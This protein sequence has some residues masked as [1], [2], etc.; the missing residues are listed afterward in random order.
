MTI[1]AAQARQIH[2]PVC[3]QHRGWTR[4]DLLDLYRQTV[5]HEAVTECHWGG[6]VLGQ[7]LPAQFQLFTTVCHQVL[8]H[9]P[10]NLLL[11][12][13]YHQHVEIVAQLEV[14]YQ[15]EAWW[16]LRPVAAHQRDETL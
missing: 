6:R 9:S 5:V 11:L 16:Y 4:L 1:F 10:P 7:V 13:R 8:H 12:R 14:T 3:G 15:L 2:F